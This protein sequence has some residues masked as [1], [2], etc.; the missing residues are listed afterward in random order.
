MKCYY[1]HAEPDYVFGKKKTFFPLNWPHLKNVRN[2]LIFSTI[3]LYFV[4]AVT[5]T[6]VKTVQ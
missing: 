6:T 2:Y 5:F 1:A 3:K 4:A